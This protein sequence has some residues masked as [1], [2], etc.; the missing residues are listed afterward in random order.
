MQYQVDL[1]TDGFRKFNSF[2]RQDQRESRRWKK[3]HARRKNGKTVIPAGP[4]IEFLLKQSNLLKPGDWKVYLQRPERDFTIYR[5]QNEFT[6][7][8]KQS[9][10]ECKKD[11]A[12]VSDD[13]IKIFKQH[14]A[15]MSTGDSD[16][17]GGSGPDHIFLNGSDNV[18]K[19]FVVFDENDEPIDLFYIEGEF[20]GH[21]FDIKFDDLIM[22]LSWV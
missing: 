5:Y 9:F 17:R 16:M 14:T 10:R 15:D 3:A 7:K 22:F 21:F 6:E 20:D 12:G 1:S 11:W 19:Y 8:V 13:Q 2:G 18:S 4:N